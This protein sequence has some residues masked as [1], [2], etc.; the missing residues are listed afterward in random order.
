[1][2]YNE[3]RTTTAQRRLNRRVIAFEDAFGDPIENPGLRPVLIPID[4]PDA[5]DEALISRRLDA[6]VSVRGRRTNGTL[7]VFQERRS[8]ELSGGDE[9]VMGVRVSASR[10]L[11]RYGSVSGGGFFQHSQ[12]VDGREDD[13]YGLNLSYSRRISADLRA[14][15]NYTHVRN[16]SDQPQNEY[17]ENRVTATLTM[18]F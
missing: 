13:I 10:T 7:S 18:L 6:S 8:F 14:V 12:F 11:S 17:V 1:V 9:D 2:G 4:E 16:E 5:T 3:S 15:V